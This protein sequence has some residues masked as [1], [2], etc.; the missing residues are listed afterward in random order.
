MG[1]IN[2][3]IVHIKAFTCDI[4][5]YR[6]LGGIARCFPHCNEHP[7]FDRFLVCDHCYTILN[8][9]PSK[10]THN[11]WCEGVILLKH[12]YSGI[13][14]IKSSLDSSLLANRLR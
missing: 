13:P 5:R 7:Q 12:F 10:T 11:K 6:Q 1:D 9:R 2:I 8:R 14:H 3:E 4:C